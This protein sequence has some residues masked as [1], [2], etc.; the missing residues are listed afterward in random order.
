M[1]VVAIMSGRLPWFRKKVIQ[2]PCQFLDVS[3][4]TLPNDENSPTAPIKFSQDPCIPVLVAKNLL[5][6]KL[7][8]C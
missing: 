4:L 3:S 1:N 5:S 8:V 6:P 2:T 7:D